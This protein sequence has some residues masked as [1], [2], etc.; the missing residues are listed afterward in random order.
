MRVHLREADEGLF[1]SH[2]WITSFRIADIRNRPG[3]YCETRFVQLRG[4]QAPGHQG[5]TMVAAI[6]A[7]IGP[8]KSYGRFI[9]G[10]A[11]VLYLAFAKLL[12]HL[13][14][15]ARYGIFRDELYYVCLL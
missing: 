12:L 5:L 15:A 1:G 4:V 8:G 11:I 3:N 14:T 7:Q 6:P 9:S 13:L 2:G 10:P